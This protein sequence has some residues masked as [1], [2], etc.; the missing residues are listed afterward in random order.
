LKLQVSMSGKNRSPE[1]NSLFN[2]CQLPIVPYV[3]FLKA[4][5]SLFCLDISKRGAQNST[6]VDNSAT[7]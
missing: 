3:E 4:F 1:L 2:S 6:Q 7:T 5:Q